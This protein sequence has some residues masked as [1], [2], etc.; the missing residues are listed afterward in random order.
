VAGVVAPAAVPRPIM[1]SGRA[2]RKADGRSATRDKLTTIALEH[3][4]DRR[5]TVCSLHQTEVDRWAVIVRNRA[6]SWM[7]TYV[8]GAARRIKVIDALK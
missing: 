4:P 1:T 7:T 3:W 2:N 5:R 6:R 8:P